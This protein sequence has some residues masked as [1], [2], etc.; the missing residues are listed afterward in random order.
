MDKNELIKKLGS[1]SVFIWSMLSICFV[2]IGVVTDSMLIM[3]TGIGSLGI[4]F[5]TGIFFIVRGIIKKKKN[6]KGLP[7]TKRET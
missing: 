1:A 7:H 4:M 6:E 3:F 2:V 5:L